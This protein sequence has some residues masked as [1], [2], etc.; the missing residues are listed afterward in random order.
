M[1][2]YL[3]VVEVSAWAKALKSFCCW[4]GAIPMPVSLTAKCRHDLLLRPRLH[5]D[6][7]HHLSPLG[8]LDGVADQVDED[9]AQ[10]A[11]VAR[12]G[13]GHVGRDVVG[14][15]Q[16]FLVG[17]QGERGHGVVQGI[18]E[19]EVDEIQV[20]LAGLDLGE[21]EDVVDHGQ[22]VIGRELHHPEVLAL[23][24]G[25][26][27]VESQLGHADDAVH[28]RAD[29]VAH[30]GQ[31]LAL[32]AGGRLGGLLGLAHR[33]LGL[34]FGVDVG[35][36]PDPFPDPAPLGQDGDGPDEHVPI[37]SV[38]PPQPV[39]DLVEGARRRRPRTTPG[40]CS[41]GRRGGRRRASPSPCSWSNVWPVNA[42]QPGCSVSNSPEAGV[43]QTMATVASISDRNRSSP[44]RRASSAR[45]P[46]VMSREMPNVPTMRPSSSR[47]GSLVV[48]TQV[49]RPPSHVSLSSL[50]ITG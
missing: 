6:P 30:V 38:V 8:E 15:L 17:A 25:E 35:V 1:P 10:A 49:T 31:E 5:V 22:Q 19:V 34:L 44:W 20:E 14:E 13:I 7:E 40:R 29:L 32:G 42:V 45:F 21:V 4:S 39:F 47:S 41:A 33:G 3:R 9:L 2:P 23:L 24:G 11:G 26:L 50:P 43:F 12:E 46:A 18:A 37:L 36:H 16:P 28:G 48:D 27:G